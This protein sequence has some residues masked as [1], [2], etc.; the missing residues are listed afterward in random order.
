MLPHYADKPGRRARYRA[1][2]RN[3]CVT[4]VMRRGCYAGDAV[5]SLQE[6]T[7]LNRRALHISY[8]ARG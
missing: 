1:G 6:L 7:C 4:A 5:K 2:T 3:E 8:E